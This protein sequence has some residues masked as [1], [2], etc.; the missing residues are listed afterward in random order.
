VSPADYASARIRVLFV[1]HRREL[2]G[3]PSSLSYL[4][5]S[6]DTERF[7]PHV[8]TPSGPAAELFEESG[9]T[10]HTGPV[11][12]FTHIWASVYRGRRWLLLLRELLLLGP[13]VISLR[14]VIRSNHFDVVHLNDS[15]LIP[16]ALVAHRA[17]I[18]IVWHLR[19]ALPGDA[20]DL[21]S[22]AIKRLI[23][24]LAAETIAI[25]DDVAASFGSHGKIIPNAVDLERFRPGDPQAAKQA[26][27]IDP[28]RYTVAFFGFIYPSKGF[29]EFID[30]AASLRSRGISATYLLVGGAVRSEAFFRTPLGWLLQRLDLARNYESEARQR[31]KALGLENEMRFVPFTRDTADLYRASDVVVAPSRGPELGRPI[32]EAAASGV[33]IIASGSRTGGSVLLPEVSGVLL[34]TFEPDELANAIQALLNDDE[35]RTAMGTAARQL[36]TERFDARTNSDLVEAIYRRVTDREGPVRILYVHHRPQL[37]GAPASLAALIRELDPRFEPHVFS[38]EGE[39]A[40]L[41]RQAGARVHTGPV[42]IFSH[43]WDSPYSGLR[44]LILGREAASLPSHVRRLRALLGSR[45]FPIVHL[46]DSPLLPAAML[47]HRSGS[48]VVWHLRSALSGGGRD[49]R[50]RTITS[51][52]DRWGDAAIAID[53]DV[54]ARFPLSLPLSI[55]HNSVRFPPPDLVPE[56]ARRELNLPEDRVLIGFAGFIRRQKGW[57]ELVRAA[58]LLVKEGLPVQFVIIGGGV[59]PPEYFRT[60]RGRLL[61]LLNIVLDEESAIRADVAKRGLTDRF[62]FLPFTYE[63]AK[64][65]AALDIVTFPNQGVGLGRP[66][67]EAAAHGKPVVASGSSTGATLLVPDETGILLNAPTPEEIAQALR[68]LVLDP[69]L[70]HKMGEAAALR[71][72]RKFDP[73]QNARAVEAVYDRLLSRGEQ[74][75]AAFESNGSDS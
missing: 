39:A 20:D 16:A 3:A 18:P 34:D 8:Y 67:L 71:A 57:P 7:D 25:N 14:R 70:R 46:N 52:M 66:V 55:V 41:F 30:A 50:A 6:L 45:R 60:G 69:E 58:E 49:W 63:T 54:A 47:A 26:L 13:H 62:S 64:I 44:W 1:H 61:E 31:V 2:G 32:L 17:G 11:S 36:A 10:V 28:A 21:R 4:I 35:R 48:K 56:T 37:G 9:A 23:R 12:A 42:S 29:R 33:P 65:Y 27:A 43:A 19:S 68:R 15:P 22:R 40:D 51:L 5:D 74:E 24:R 72:R 53:E 73:A 38:P 75:R 59:R